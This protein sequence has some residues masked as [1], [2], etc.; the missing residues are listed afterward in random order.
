[1][2]FGNGHDLTFLHAT[3]T[4]AVCFAATSISACTWRTH[5]QDYDE[6]DKWALQAWPRN[7]AE[8]D[9]VYVVREPW[10][11][12]TLLVAQTA[13]PREARC[14][15]PRLLGLPAMRLETLLR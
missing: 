13:D 11:S 4:V 12:S 2:H 15:P 8:D 10:L 9:L 6:E 7:N 5:D 14:Q 1:M 3:L